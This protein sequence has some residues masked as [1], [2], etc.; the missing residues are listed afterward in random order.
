MT[1]DMQEDSDISVVKLTYKDF[2]GGDATMQA[3][4]RRLEVVN[5]C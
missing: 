1:R 2:I 5:L 3:L 4:P